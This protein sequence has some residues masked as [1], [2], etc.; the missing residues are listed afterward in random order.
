M[1]HEKVPSGVMSM[2]SILSQGF[3]NP[4][5]EYWLGTE[6]IFAITSQR[7]YMLRIELMDWEGNRAYSQY[8]R[9]HIGNEK[10]NYR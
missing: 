6:F 2:C 1:E 3:G 5:G 7:Q 10:Q 9:F 4:S 8:D